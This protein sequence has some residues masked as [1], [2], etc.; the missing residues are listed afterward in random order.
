[1]KQT[2]KTL[3]LITALGASLILAAC[4]GGSSTGGSASNEATTL[5]QAKIDTSNQKEVTALLFDSVDALT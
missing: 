3:T 4:G 2:K 5:P 1:M